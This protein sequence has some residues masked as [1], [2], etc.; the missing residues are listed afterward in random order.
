M[1]R[2]SSDTQVNPRFTVDFRNGRVEDLDAQKLVNDLGS[3][4]G[5]QDVTFVFNK[6]NKCVE[7]KYQVKIVQTKDGLAQWH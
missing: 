7:K 3:S 2:A 6:Q 4:E 1:S 5:W